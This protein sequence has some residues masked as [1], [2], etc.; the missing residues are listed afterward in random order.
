MIYLTGDVHR[1]LY[2]FLDPRLPKE[3]GDILIILGDACINYYKDVSDE[4][5]KQFLS[6]YDNTFFIIQGNHEERPENINTYKEKEMFG[7][8]VFVEDDYPNL[9]FAKN[10]ELYNIENNKVLVIGGAYS[11]DKYYRLKD[12]RPWFKD[13]QL[14]AEEKKYILD[15]YSGEKVDYIL[16][17]TCPNKYIPKEAF[18][19]G[20]DESLI[21]H[22]M[23]EFLDVV[24]E[25][26]EYD[27]WYCGHYHIE[28]QIDKIEF[29]FEN[30]KEL[31]KENTKE[32]KIKKII[33]LDV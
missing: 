22:S 1:D 9:V 7:G 17:H 27:K 13:E 21:D 32:K 20:L 14:T 15:K 23:E 16:S 30:T 10:G 29:M 33:T 31:S 6:N 12:N 2:R 24:E 5:V 11:V 25:N 18:I 26:I 3:K 28:K 8:K 19:D 4:M